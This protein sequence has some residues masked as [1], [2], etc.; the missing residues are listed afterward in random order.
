MLLLTA[1]TGGSCGVTDFSAG[2]SASTERS[3]V[4]AH[5]LTLAVIAITAARN[6]S[7]AVAL[8]TRPCPATHNSQTRESNSASDESQL[9]GGV[10]SDTLAQH[11]GP[12][13]PCALQATPSGRHTRFACGAV[14][15]VL[16]G[17]LR[18][19]HTGMRRCASQ[20]NWTADVP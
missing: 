11:D 6:V 9:R 8:I 12:E 19:Q 14:A 13:P 7:F 20:Q 18:F 4:C 3:R 5:A 2:A 15:A 1:N 10:V 16:P 17:M